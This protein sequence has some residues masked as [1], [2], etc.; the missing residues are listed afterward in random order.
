[1]LHCSTFIGIKEIIL[2]KYTKFLL[3]SL[4]LLGADVSWAGG[5]LEKFTP[6][7]DFKTDILFKNSLGKDVRISDFKGAPVVLALWATWC[8][9][10][11]AEMPALDRLQK[12]YPN[13]QIIP[14]STDKKGMPKV[15]KFYTKHSIE[16]LKIYTDEKSIV[17]DDLSLKS[18]PYTIVYDSSGTSVGYWDSGV[19]FDS[20]SVV[21]FLLSIK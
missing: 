9:P 10:C 5:G 15:K 11:I 21:N 12:Q 20:D 16:N 8:V 17:S 4:L 3:V 2:R 13:M 19:D 14:L 1:M 7:T 18:L 6:K